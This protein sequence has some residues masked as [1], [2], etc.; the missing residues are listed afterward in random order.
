VVLS[1]AVYVVVVGGGGTYANDGY[2]FDG[3][4][5]ARGLVFGVL[6][7]CAS[8]DSRLYIDRRGMG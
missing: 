1:S 4:F 2:F 8:D 7:H 3:V 6:G 5:V